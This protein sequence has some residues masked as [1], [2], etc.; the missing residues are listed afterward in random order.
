MK[1]R[2]MLIV[3]IPVD[4]DEETVKEL[5]HEGHA[6]VK[7][8]ITAVPYLDDHAVDPAETPTVNFSY[9]YLQGD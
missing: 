5:Q 7:R 3:A 9:G 4:L 8:R 6:G 2:C 1:R